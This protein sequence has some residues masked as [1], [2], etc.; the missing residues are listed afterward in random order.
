MVIPR[1]H[2]SVGIQD[3]GFDRGPTLPKTLE[4][5]SNDVQGDVMRRN[6]VDGRGE[7]K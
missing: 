5:F 1:S 3:R 4:I 7:D 6:G 2:R